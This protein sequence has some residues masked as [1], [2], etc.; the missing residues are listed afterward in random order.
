MPFKLLGRGVVASALTIFSTQLRCCRLKSDEYR[1][2]FYVDGK[3]I[4]PPN[5]PVPPEAYPEDWRCK[6]TIESTPAHSD[7]PK[8]DIVKLTM[9]PLS[10]FIRSFTKFGEFQCNDSCACNNKVAL[11]E[12][13]AQNAS[14]DGPQPF[15]KSDDYYEAQLGKTLQMFAQNFRD[16]T[17]G[18]PLTAEECYQA[19]KG[20][21]DQIESQLG[22]LG[23]HTCVAD[24]DRYRRSYEYW[25]EICG[26]RITEAIDYCLMPGKWLYEKFAVV[27]PFAKVE[28][29]SV[30]KWPRNISPRHPHFNFL[31]AQFTK[32]MESYFYKHL[33]ATGPL[34]RWC[35]QRESGVQNPWIGKSMNKIQRGDAVGYK[36]RLFRQRWGVDP[37][38]LSTDCTGFD[39]HVTQGVIKVENRFYQNCFVKHRSFLRELTKCFE[40]NN[41]NTNGVRG[42]VRGS[43]MSG[44]MHTGLGNTVVILGMLVTSFRMMEITRYDLLSDGDD[45]LVFVHP[46][47]LAIVLKS[48]PEHFLAFGQ[49][50][51]VEK[52][53]RNIF[54]VEWCQCK[55]VRV[56][57]DGEEHYMFVQDPHKTFATMGS[58]IHCRTNEGAFKY[59]ADVLFA[60]SVMYSSIPLFRKLATY[61][62]SSDVR[63]RRLM[64]GLAFDLLN[65]SRLHAAENSNTLS[66]Y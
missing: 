50:L 65:N 62:V 11:V 33:S 34:A 24:P 13:L 18:E 25:K 20:K 58:H 44:D 47:D 19:F 45:C 5:V 56:D 1:P 15:P 23:F 10:A 54:E 39:S 2:G 53:A 32:P 30:K 60:Y 17:S 43:R 16:H 66:D 55:L 40:V 4:A 36:Y 57:V 51:R 8:R 48:L 64:P 26:V 46:D 42:K 6:Y 28:S 52:V 27:R 35:V 31:W 14:K 22:M 41:F 29:I 3:F 12:R 21:N 49:E 63:T 37:L 61:R 9:N 38:V 7:D 59:F